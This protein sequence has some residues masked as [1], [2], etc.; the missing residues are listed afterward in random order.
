VRLAPEEIERLLERAPVARLATLG[1][2]GRPHLVPIVF[3][4]AA[5][6]LWSPVDGK[7][8]APGPLARVRNV[9]R[10]PRVAL[11]VDHYEDDWT[12]LWWVRL[13]GTAR[14]VRAAAET[15]PAVAPA[16]AALRAKYPQY[17]AMP[18]FRGT[19]TLLRIAVERARGW[20]A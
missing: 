8:K 10:D 6:A 13:E 3:A 4:Q 17:A 18:L 15:D 14:V 11:L 19:P 20:R 2:R 12:R 16:V 9:E 5:G 1:A 7:P